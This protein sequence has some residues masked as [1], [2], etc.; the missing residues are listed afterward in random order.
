MVAVALAGGLLQAAG[1]LARGSRM[2]ETAREAAFTGQN[3]NETPNS[4][5]VLGPGFTKPFDGTQFD[6][7]L[8]AR[9]QNSILIHE[10]LHTYTGLNDIDLA[11]KLGLGTFA[12]GKAA[13]TGIADF[14][15]DGCRPKSK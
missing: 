1:I 10:V 14:L 15:Y 13:S 2:R 7:D 3:A 5:I 12:S 9:Y 6:S 4:Q 8:L 11:E